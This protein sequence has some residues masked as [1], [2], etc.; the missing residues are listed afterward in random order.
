[1]WTEL[2][3]ANSDNLVEELDSLIER[4]KEYSA[5]IKTGEPEALYDMLREGSDR[6]KA[7]NDE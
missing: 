2:F 3:L 1:M 4:L 6:K 7:L 5:V